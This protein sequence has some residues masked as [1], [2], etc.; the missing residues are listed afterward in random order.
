MADEEV[1]TPEPQEKKCFGL[2]EKDVLRFIIP[3][4]TSFVGCLL[5]LAVY[6]SLIGK[7]PI[8]PKHCPPPPPPCQRIEAP[9]PDGPRHLRGHRGEF[10]QQSQDAKVETGKKTHNPQK[11]IKKHKKH[12]LPEAPVAL[13]KSSTP[14]K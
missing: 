4:A 13:E 6:A 14:Q 12:H 3:C 5:A 8:G 1:K 9:R 2:K 11:N 7:P 10:K